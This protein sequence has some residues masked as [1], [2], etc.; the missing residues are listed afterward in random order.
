MPG[1]IR[2]PRGFQAGRAQVPRLRF[3]TRYIAPQGL[4]MSEYLLFWIVLAHRYGLITC[5]EYRKLTA[6]LY[7]VK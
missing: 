3:R 5:T 6:N 4:K 7:G 2:W 1:R